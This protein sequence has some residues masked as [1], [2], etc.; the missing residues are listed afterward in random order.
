MKFKFNFQTNNCWFY[1]QKIPTD[2]QFTTKFGDGGF[3]IDKNNPAHWISFT[4]YEKRIR[5]FYKKAH[6]NQPVIYYRKD[7]PLQEIIEWEFTEADIITKIN[8]TW[9]KR[10]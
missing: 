2:Q 5:A 4:I 7:L 6:L 10:N 9:Q 1:Q 8:G 3:T